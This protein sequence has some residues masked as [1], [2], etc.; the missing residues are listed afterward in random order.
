MS[1]QKPWCFR[2]TQESIEKEV[3]SVTAILETIIAVLLYWWIALQV[4]VVLP[5]LISAAVAPLVLL[6][7]ES[8]VAL[9]LQWFLRIPW[10][11]TER[12]E[13]SPYPRTNWAILG[14]VAALVLNMV[15]TLSMALSSE[16][17]IFSLV[18][19]TPPDFFRA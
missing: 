4:G 17:S 6:R 13:Y 16:H 3:P 7:S 12:T 9:G 1:G 2:S 8:A 18:S 15:L 11:T 14:T 19:L 5:L 10:L